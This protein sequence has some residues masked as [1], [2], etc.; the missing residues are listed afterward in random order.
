[1]PVDREELE[2]AA[3]SLR[4]VLFGEHNHELG[5]VGIGASDIHVYVHAGKK[6]WAGKHVASWDGYSVT[7]HYKVGPIVAQTAAF[8]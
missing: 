4:I 6:A 7:W 3:R 2:S 5:F 1:M 8:V